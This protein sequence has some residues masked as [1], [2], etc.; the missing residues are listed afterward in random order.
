MGWD[1]VVVVVVGRDL[2]TA[3]S[4]RVAELIAWTCEHGQKGASRAVG[5]G[6]EGWGVG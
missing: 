6:Q 3:T 4:R 1:G 5:G 2:G